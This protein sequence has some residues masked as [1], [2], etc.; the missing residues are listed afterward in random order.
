MPG[1]RSLTKPLG[2]MFIAHVATV[3]LSFGCACYPEFFL[4][5]I[6]LYIVFR[7][8]N[9]MLMIMVTTS[10]TCL[11]LVHCSLLA[12]IIPEPVNPGS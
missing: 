2:M 1:M 9:I 6:L 12:N 11:K 3:V 10:M 7:W 8:S 4:L 5:S